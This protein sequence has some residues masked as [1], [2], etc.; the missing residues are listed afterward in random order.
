[1]PITYQKMMADTAKVTFYWGEDDVNVVYHP[2]KV[3]EEFM[4]QVLAFERMD[5]ATFEKTFTSFNATLADII[6]SWDV[7]D[8]KEM[9]PLDVKAFKRLPLPFRFQVAYAIM[10]DMR[11]ERIAPQTKMLN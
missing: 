2:G 11:P 10:G 1:M 8:G 4:G 3:T 7:F 5:A 9:F 6:E